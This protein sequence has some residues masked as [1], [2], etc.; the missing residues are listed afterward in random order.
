MGIRVRYN[1]GLLV[2]HAAFLAVETEREDVLV[3]GQVVE[4]LLK[5]LSLCRLVLRGGF[6]TIK[7]L[8]TG[9]W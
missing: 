4:E 3:L 2:V 8:G 6:N 9:R 7:A 5:R 1:V